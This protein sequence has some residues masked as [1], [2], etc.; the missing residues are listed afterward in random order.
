[1][2]VTGPHEEVAEF[3]TT[4][5]QLLVPS[6][7]LV[8]RG[9]TLVRMEATGAHGNPCTWI[10][11]EPSRRCGSSTPATCA[12]SL[13]A[14]PSDIVASITHPRHRAVVV[15]PKGRWHL[16]VVAGHRRDAA[17]FGVVDV[18]PGGLVDRNDR[19]DRRADGL[20]LRTPI[21]Y[22]QPDRS[23][24]SNTFVFQS[25]LSARSSLVVGAPAR[26]TRAVSSSVKRRSSHAPPSPGAGRTARTEVVAAR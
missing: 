22:C 1:M 19:N 26:L 25:P 8:E 5:S 21:E 4:T 14:R 10:L 17:F 24:R 9:V 7:W 2:A 3:R 6:D 15:A 11:E 20:D 13:V 12:T 23:R 18:P 16:P